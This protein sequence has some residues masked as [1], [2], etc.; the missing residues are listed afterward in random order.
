MDGLRKEVEDV[1]ILMQDN[2]QKI[3]VN[4][5]DLELIEDKTDNLARNSNRFKKSVVELKNKIWCQNLKVILII[6]WTI[7]GILSLIILFIVLLLQK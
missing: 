5:D 2:I 6:V 1:K 3:I 4:T 7:L